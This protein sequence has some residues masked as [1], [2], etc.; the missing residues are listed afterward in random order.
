MDALLRPPTILFHDSLP[1]LGQGSFWKNESHDDRNLLGG[2]SLS[3]SF[4]GGRS[5][6]MFQAERTSQGSRGHGLADKALLYKYEG[7]SLDPLSP[8]KNQV[9]V[10]DCL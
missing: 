3:L 5:W 4:S 6:Q 10:V 8:N 7:Q 2:L 1:Q 9:G